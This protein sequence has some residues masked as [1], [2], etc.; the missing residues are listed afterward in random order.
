MTQPIIMFEH[1]KKEFGTK[2]VLHDLHFS[3]LKG[4]LLVLVGPSGSGKTTILKL[5]NQLL[6]PT[7][8][9]ILFKGKNIQTLNIKKIRWNMGYVLQKIALFPNM[10]VK[11]NIEVIPEMM[12]WSKEKRNKRTPE[13]LHEVNLNPKEYLNRYP[14]E[15]SGGEQQRIGILRAI[16]AK[17]SILLMD[18][19]FS[20]LDPISRKSLQNVVKHIHN[21][22]NTT[23]VF[24]THD[25]DEALRL[26]DRIALIHQGKIHQIA[27]PDVLL[28]QPKDEFVTHFFK[29]TL[30]KVPF[31]DQPLSHFLNHKFLLPKKQECITVNANQSIKDVMTQLNRLNQVNIFQKDTIIGSV[32]SKELLKLITMRFI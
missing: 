29:E 32:R 12:G 31:L 3:I 18:E 21:T 8:G 14:H 28:N 30:A 26:A 20:A 5:I 24:V 1:V 15:L 27:S 9:E 11:Q 6:L 25:M 17:P 13:L 4:E 2:K 23:I 22:T 10:T 16:A 7:K 19:P